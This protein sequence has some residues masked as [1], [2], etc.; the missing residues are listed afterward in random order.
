MVSGAL[1][2]HGKVATQSGKLSGEDNPSDQ[3]WAV[4]LKYSMS[5][6]DH[7]STLRGA[8]PLRPRNPP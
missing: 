1:E 2:F 8:I 7:P 6:Q 4:L 3:A 5:M